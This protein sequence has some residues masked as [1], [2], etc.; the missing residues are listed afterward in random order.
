MATTIQTIINNARNTLIETTP[1]FWADSELLEYAQNA[2]KDLWRSIVDLNQ[3]HF[4]TIEESGAVTHPPDTNYLSGIPSNVYRVEL[5]ELL[6]LTST[7]TVI[8]V[9]YFPR[10]INHPDFTAA[11]A[12]AAVDPSGRTIFFTLLGAG[13]PVG[14]PQILVAPQLTA[15]LTLRLVY[16]A[17]LPTLGV[18]S[19]N[20][21]PGESDNAIKAYILANALA[22]E[23][24]DRRPDPVWL[25]MYATEKASILS[26][27]TPRQ[28]V[29]PDYAEALFEP[30]W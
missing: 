15:T 5:I 29:E 23:R 26:S 8:D 7:A 17:I 13:N 28:V 10:P 30:W 27:L 1:K 9:T 16:T 25:Q 19:T 11:R 14:V 12:L 6:D 4:V 21:I 3:N 22:K 2:C 24:E 18:S 20:P